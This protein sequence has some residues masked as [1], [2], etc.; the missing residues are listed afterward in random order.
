MIRSIAPDPFDAPLA[1][2]QSI[3]CWVVFSQHRPEWP[4]KSYPFADEGQARMFLDYCKRS[5]D[6]RYELRTLA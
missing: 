5:G 2:R 6:H 1:D 4:G 3:D